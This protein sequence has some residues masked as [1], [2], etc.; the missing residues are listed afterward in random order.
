MCTGSYAYTSTVKKPVR[1]PLK[2]GWLL[3]NSLSGVYVFGIGAL[4][5]SQA[6]F[7]A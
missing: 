1:F 3:C 5:S 2:S 6:Y 4:S 7:P